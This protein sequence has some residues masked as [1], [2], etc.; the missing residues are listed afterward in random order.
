MDAYA[1]V[2]ASGETLARFANDPLLS[3]GCHTHRHIPCGLL[4]DGEVE[5]DIRRALDRLAAVG[6]K[7]RHF[8]F[9][10]GH[11]EHRASRFA[12]FFESCGFVS[13]VTTFKGFV[14]PGASDPLFLPRIGVS[15]Y[16]GFPRADSLPRLRIRLAL[17]GLFGA[18]AKGTG[19]PFGK[20]AGGR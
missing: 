9:P 17:K 3:I 16:R 15:E 6:V 8:A 2:A 13:A 18:F 1:T 14:T 4:S 5:A 10:Y 11:D 12:A 19:R 7:P 20:G